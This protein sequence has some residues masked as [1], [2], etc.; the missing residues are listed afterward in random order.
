[1]RYLRQAFADGRL[2]R[3][4][5]TDYFPQVEEY[6]KLAQKYHFVDSVEMPVDARNVPEE[7]DGARVI[8][9]GF[10]HFKPQDAKAIMKSAYDKRAVFGVFETPERTA[11]WLLFISLIPSF[12]LA[13]VMTARIRP[14]R[15][16]HLVFGYLIP[17]VPLM[18]CWDNVVSGLRAYSQDELKDMVSDLD[19]PDYKWDIGIAPN[20]DPKAPIK[21]ISYVIGSPR[22]A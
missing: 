15:W 1:V 2:N 7:L 21:R 5:V 3:L 8:V 10:H 18:F 20:K 13:L 9:R 22:L 19:A 11:R 4:K 17:I 14:F 16:H 12:I 6:R